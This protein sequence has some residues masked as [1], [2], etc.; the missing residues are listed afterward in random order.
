VFTSMD[1]DD[2]KYRAPALS[3][4]LDILELLAGVQ[5]GLSQAEIAKAL[6]RT[7]SEIFR[8]LMVLRNRG[9]L[10]LAEDADRYTLTARLFEIAH[11]HP[12]IN[13]LTS[14][15]SDAME[16]LAYRINQ[17]LHLNILHEAKTLVIAQMDSHDSTQTCV[18]LGARFPL[19]SAASGRVL[20][21]WMPEPEL[22]VILDRAGFDTPEALHQ[23]R[24]ELEEVRQVGYCQLPSGTVAGVQKIAAPIFD[25]RGRVVAAL[26]IPFVQRLARQQAVSLEEA[27]HALVDTCTKIS[28]QMGGGAHQPVSEP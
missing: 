4:G 9:Y 23:F 14:L 22:S 6:G 12:P 7:S 20:V 13:R 24:A 27:R 18:R 16:R 5:N 19:A 26:T 21:A 11:R 15:A 10:D 3:K 25:F 8:M 1:F 2:E 17:S 28:R